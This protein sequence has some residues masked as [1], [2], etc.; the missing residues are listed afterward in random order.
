MVLKFSCRIFIFSTKN[1]LFF[2]EKELQFVRSSYKRRH[3]ENT[4]L[5][6]G[7][8][9][10]IDIENILLCIFEFYVLLAVYC[11]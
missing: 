11:T 5:L 3:F 4:I 9:H 7:N 1:V 8:D 10:V 6:A 2:F